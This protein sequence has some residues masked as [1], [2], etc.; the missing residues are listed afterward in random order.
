MSR[1]PKILDPIGA[2]IPKYRE[3]R[4]K[5]TA[6]QLARLLGIPKNTLDKI[7]QGVQNPNYEHKAIL[8]A[9]I[10]D[11]INW[12]NVPRGMDSGSAGVDHSA[13]REELLRL[14]RDQL[15]D[16][17]E[18]LLEA[19]E[20][21]EQNKRILEHLKVLRDQVQ[22]SLAI[23]SNRLLWNQATVQTILQREAARESK[24]SDAKK[25]QILHG[26]NKQIAANLKDSQKTGS[27]DG[28]G[29]AGK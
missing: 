6:S 28:D 20:E 11:P 25:D 7:E 5:I 15:Q 10:K 13:D 19:K 8:Q 16:Q 22:A 12:K 1:R 27:Q 9:W 2:T 17:R 21:K 24:G 4:N 29:K 14:M 23:I 18:R 3:E 26:I